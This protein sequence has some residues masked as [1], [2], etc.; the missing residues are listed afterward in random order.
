M[1]NGEDEDEIS[2]ELA[3]RKCKRTFNDPRLL[4]CGETMCQ[5]CIQE[6]LVQDNHGRSLTCLFCNETHTI[7]DELPEN[8]LIHKLIDIKSSAS[9]SSSLSASNVCC[10]ELTNDLNDVL[11]SLE[12]RCRELKYISAASYLAEIRNYS[13]FIQNDIEIVTQSM[14]EYVNRFHDELIEQVS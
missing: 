11:V 12:R 2:R 8:K 7:V 10:K 9:S 14:L 4:P 3:C 13:E 1:L 6:Q 5:R